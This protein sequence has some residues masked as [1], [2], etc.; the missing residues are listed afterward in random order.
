[1][2]FDT[3]LH[4]IYPDRLRYPWLKNLEVLNKPSKYEEYQLLAKRLGI[5]SCFHMEVDVAEEQII[6]ETNLIEE[7][8]HRSKTLLRGVISACRPEYENFP[9]FLDWANE[10][11]LIKGFRRVLHVVPD[12]ISQTKLFRNN[13]KRLS[14][15]KLTFDL[16]VSSRQLPLTYELVDYCPEV[17][18]V[19]DHCGVP[20]IQSNDF[21]DWAPKILELSKRNNVYCKI[22]GIIAYGNPVFW[23]LDE[24]RPYFEHAISSFGHD[25]IVWGSDSPVCN[26]GGNLETWVAIT[27]ILT[28]DWSKS[29]RAALFSKNAFHLWDL[30]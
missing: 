27:H 25:R 6:D 30:V 4:L 12:E 9:K 20:D 19:L 2:L 21:H 26:L 3:H 1:M 11:S 8:T 23:T 22:S 15:T 18:F 14:E 17:T 28:S 5:S 29:D 13:V 10:Q 24:L 16:C 7:I